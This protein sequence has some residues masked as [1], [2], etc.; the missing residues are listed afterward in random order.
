MND[1]SIF[2]NNNNNKFFFYED[3]KGNSNQTRIQFIKE[4][5]EENLK[6]YSNINNTKIKE[7]IKILLFDINVKYIDDNDIGEFLQ[8]NSKN[9]K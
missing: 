3:F 1:I 5:I 4:N 7:L 2:K 8:N 9:E 6:K